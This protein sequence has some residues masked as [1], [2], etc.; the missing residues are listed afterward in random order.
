MET[1]IRVCPVCGRNT[2]HRRVPFVRVGSP[3]QD[4]I[5]KLDPATKDD[6]F[7]ICEEHEREGAERG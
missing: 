5:E 6:K 2:K 1:K 7:W 3:L 4:S